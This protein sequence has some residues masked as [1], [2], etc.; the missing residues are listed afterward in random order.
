[1]WKRRG[2][3]RQSKCF[4]LFFGPLYSGLLGLTLILSGVWCERLYRWATLS[5]SKQ[6][7]CFSFL[8]GFLWFLSKFG[9]WRGK[10]E[11]NTTERR[12]EGFLWLNWWGIYSNMAILWETRWSILLRS[13]AMIMELSPK[14]LIR[15][16][17]LY[18]EKITLGY[19]IPTWPGRW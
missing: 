13:L 11:K 7:W 2:C 6:S 1:M 12:F 10:T 3:T 17:F 14:Y 5:Y 19:L 16:I 9:I 4:C 18:A 8:W 15:I